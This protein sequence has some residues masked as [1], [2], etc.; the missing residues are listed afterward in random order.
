MLIGHE[1][2]AEI[3]EKL[4]LETIE[5]SGTPELKSCAL[6]AVEDRIFYR[7]VFSAQQDGYQADYAFIV[8]AITG[9]I[10]E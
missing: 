2:A 1:A 8:H 9:D 6:E 5:T 7:V 4:L 3:A 10:L